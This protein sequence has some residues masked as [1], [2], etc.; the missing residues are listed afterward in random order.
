M[1]AG[2]GERTVFMQPASNVLT[3]EQLPVFPRR[4]GWKGEVKS[5]KWKL[6]VVMPYPNVEKAACRGIS[7][8]TEDNPS[9][10]TVQAM[11]DTCAS[12][13][14]AQACAWWGMAHEMHGFFGGMNAT[15]RAELR[16]S[17]G[18]GVIEPV[19]AYADRLNDSWNVPTRTHCEKGHA[20]RPEVDF[21]RDTPTDDDRYRHVYRIKCSQCWFERYESP[22]ARAIRGAAGKKGTA[23]LKAKGAYQRVEHRR[24]KHA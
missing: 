22:E 3:P 12:C 20:L 7:Q 8:F 4:W 5:G 17:I 1:A 2:S 13:P 23:A 9:A 6:I 14:I 10:T 16:A 21:I 18:L 24:F 15:E 19:N 11:R